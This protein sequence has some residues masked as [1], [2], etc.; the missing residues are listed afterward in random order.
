MLYQAAQSR[1]GNTTKSLIRFQ[2]EIFVSPSKTN[3]KSLKY[4]ADSA[5]EGGG[6]TKI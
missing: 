6:G 3:K 5:S 4:V 1:A 2:N